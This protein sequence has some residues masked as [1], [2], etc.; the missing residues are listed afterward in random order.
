[1]RN[2]TLKIYE[3]LNRG[4]FISADSSD[5]TAKHLFEDIEENY[6]DYADY[7]K[8]IGLRLEA[9]NGYYFFSRIS[10]GKQS[11]E[12]KLDSFSKWL[13]YLDFLK[14]YDQSFTAGFQFRKTHI[15][16]QISVDLELKEK[17]GRLFK[18]YDASSNQDIVTKLI[19][20][21]VTTGFA[22]CINE[23]DE[24]YKVTSAFRYAEDLVNM[25]QIANEDEIP[26]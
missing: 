20:E 14:C 11:M 2:N 23:T 16:E 5:Y 26:E 13:D 8:E 15:I 10:E 24:T 18:K 19:Q 3:I 22:E 17:A 4:G 7:Y 21:M 12:Q 6:E 1:M 25:I 9:G